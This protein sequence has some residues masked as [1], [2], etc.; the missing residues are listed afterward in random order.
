MSRNILK[1]LLSIEND[2]MNIVFILSV[3]GYSFLNYEK[4]RKSL[5]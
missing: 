5:Q 4:I 2:K 3:Y 1:I